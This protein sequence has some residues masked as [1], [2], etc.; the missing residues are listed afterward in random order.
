MTATRGFT[1]VPNVEPNELPEEDDMT[2]YMYVITFGVFCLG[3]FIGYSKGKNNGLSEATYNQQ[4]LD[5][6]RIWAEQMRNCI[7]GSHE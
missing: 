2:V 3:Y 5:A 6:T 1:G 7:G 4:Q